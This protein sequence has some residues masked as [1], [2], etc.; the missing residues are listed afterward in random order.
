MKYLI[1]LFV[2][3]ICLMPCFAQNSTINYKAIIKD[4]IGNVIANQEI[5]VRFI[6]RKTTGN[7]FYIENHTTTTDSNGLI[8]LSIGEGVAALG[9]FE[10]FDWR[11]NNYSLRVG[12]DIEQDG[13]F[14]YIDDAEFKSVPYALSS[15]DNLWRKN[16]DDAYILADKIGIGTQEPSAQLSIQD[17]LISSIKLVTP[18]FYTEGEIA[19]E[20]GSKDAEYTFFKISN[21]QDRFYIAADS[22]LI[23][24]TDYENI[25]E[26]SPQGNIITQGSLRLDNGVSVN[27][28]SNDGTLSGNSDTVVPTESAIKAYVDNATATEIRKIAIPGSAFHLHRIDD[29]SVDETKIFFPLTGGVN[30]IPREFNIISPDAEYYILAPLILP[31]NNILTSVKYVFKDDFLG[32]NY[33]FSIIKNCSVTS[34]LSIIVNSSSFEINSNEVNFRDVNF[35]EPIDPDCSYSIIIEMEENGMLTNG[36]NTYTETFYHAIITYIEN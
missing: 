12:L 9:D 13:S 23:S 15:A 22:D 21:K 34:D 32:Y 16:G 28:F 33:R 1:T 31:A 10:E 24:T 26:L 6:I 2:V 17:S 5:N 27:E 30:F 25:F 7:N 3:T 20:N 8:I 36:G 4:D 35:L 11:A 29:E 18:F 19:F 14:I